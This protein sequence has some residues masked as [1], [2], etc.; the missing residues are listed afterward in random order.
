MNRRYDKSVLENA[1]SEMLRDVILRL[2][3]DYYVRDPFMSFNR[4]V[5]NKNHYYNAKEMF[6]LQHASMIMIY[7]R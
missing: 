4:D 3:I 1:L 6:S 7:D 5:W 2:K